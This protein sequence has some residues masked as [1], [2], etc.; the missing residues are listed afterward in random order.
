MACLD[1]VLLEQLLRGGLAGEALA[2]VD[3]HLDGCADCRAKL[4]RAARKA[5]S[6]PTRNERGAVRELEPAPDPF[7]GR[8]IA[9]RYH[10]KRRIGGGGMGTVYEAEHVL[11][12]RR[13]ALKVLLPQWAS[14]REVVRRF[15]NEAR[16]AGTLRHPGILEALDMGRTEEGTPYLVLDY[17]EGRDLEA[18]M[19]AEAPLSVRESVEIVRTIGD[20]VAAAHAAGIIHRDL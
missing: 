15:Q 19:A 16:A 8:V 18:K 14:E 11:I 4:G 10:V 6:T 9:D 2:E 7:L 3:A 20:A 5:A 17:L 1:D 12:G 13:V